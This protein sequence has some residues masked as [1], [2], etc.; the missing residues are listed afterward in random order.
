ML[1]ARSSNT[2]DLVKPVNVQIEPKFNTR[3]LQFSLNQLKTR[4]FP[5]I[6]LRR[7]VTPRWEEFDSVVTGFLKAFGVGVA[8]GS[9]GT[10]ETGSRFGGTLIRK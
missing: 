3:M 10:L 6:P 5:S 7:V 4:C 1:S 2:S 8:V 9:F